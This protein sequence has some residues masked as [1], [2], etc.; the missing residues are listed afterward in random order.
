MANRNSHLF[1][2]EFTPK[3]LYIAIHIQTILPTD[4]DCSIYTG[5]AQD[6][7]HALSLIK[8][9]NIK[10]AVIFSDSFSILISIQNTFRP[11]KIAGT[12][13]N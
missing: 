9:I 3:K 12:I 6:I 7:V 5:E 13:Q 2:D 1:R 8:N 4:E 10:I 11:N